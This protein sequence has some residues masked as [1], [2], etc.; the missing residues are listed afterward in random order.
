[1]T[2][3]GPI[4]LGVWGLPGNDDRGHLA[5][6]TRT[7]EQSPKD[8]AVESTDIP[9]LWSKGGARGKDG[10]WRVLGQLPQG[11][12]IGTGAL[13]DEEEFTK[14]FGKG[15]LGRGISGN[16]RR[17]EKAGHVLSLP[18][19]S[20]GLEHRGGSCSLVRLFA[21]RLGAPPTTVP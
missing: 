5:T 4:I 10:D 11:E 7:A 6:M 2:L 18:S 17:Q 14:E 3:A 15:I 16:H 19:G 9:S 12:D 1:M 21:P 13:M 8:I 20:V